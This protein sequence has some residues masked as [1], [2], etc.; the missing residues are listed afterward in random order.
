MKG[1]EPLGSLEDH[2][3]GQ[4]PL[5]GPLPPDSP[6]VESPSVRGAA[7][8]PEPGVCV[9]KAPKLVLF[10]QI[11]SLAFFGSQ[12]LGTDDERF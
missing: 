2:E 10:A 3:H 8:L 12:T 9:N 6:R 7:E 4:G 11:T 1:Q 5:V